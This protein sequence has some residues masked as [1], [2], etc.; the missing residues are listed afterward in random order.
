MQGNERV[1]F[2]EWTIILRAGFFRNWGI[3]NCSI[4]EIYAVR[5]IANGT[6]YLAC[7][8][9]QL[10]E[11]RRS[12]PLTLACFVPSAFVLN[13]INN[14][15]NGKLLLYAVKIY[16]SKHFLIIENSI[17]NNSYWRKYTC[18]VY[19]LWTNIDFEAVIRNTYNTFEGNL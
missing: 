5:I 13:P 15:L 9:S 7:I 19:V 16:S 17:V 1:P 12:R 14:K 6:S 11:D 10:G 2:W 3:R 18:T 4:V 8:V